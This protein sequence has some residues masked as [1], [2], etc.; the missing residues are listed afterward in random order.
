LLKYE[1]VANQLEDLIRTGTFGVGDRLPSIR[2]LSRDWRVSVATVTEAYRTLE[3]RRVVESRPQSGF[4]VLPKRHLAAEPTLCDFECEPKSPSLSDVFLEIIRGLNSNKNLPLGGA[5]PNTRHLPTKK[6]YQAT[7]TAARRYPERTNAYE[8]PEGAKELR[9]ELAK[10]A[11]TAGMTLHP[12]DFIVTNGCHEALSI[13]LSV[14][15]KPG[16][17]IALE[18]PA[19]FGTVFNILNMDLKIL[20]I[21]TSPQDGISLDALEF[22]MQNHDIKAVLT[23]SNFQNP[24]G[25]CPSDEKKKQLVDLCERNNT[26]LIEDDIYGDVSFDDHRP[27]TCKS[28][29]KSGIVILCSSFSKTLSPG[30]RIG[31][32]V[33][34]RYYKEMLMKKMLLNFSSPS[35]SQLGLATYFEEQSY[36]HYLRQIRRHL[37]KS[38][39]LLREFVTDYF[40]K[41]TRVTRPKGGMVIWC[42]LPKHADSVRIYQEALKHGIAIAPGT[43]FSQYGQSNHCI[44]LNASMVEEHHE[45]QIKKLGQVIDNCLKS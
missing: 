6:L 39:S 8:S 29:D 40:P 43:L 12:D 15:A 26:V 9:A 20:E 19:F 18:S 31:W 35:M 32:I 21:P 4:F 2:H 28:F 24:L 11:I 27:V 38:V 44:R 36:D 33:P 22:A 34:G 1:T 16:D 13:V 45:K 37:K 7:S 3:N 17:V 14:I 42:E 10:R 41:E 5:I 30:Y 23:I 25:S